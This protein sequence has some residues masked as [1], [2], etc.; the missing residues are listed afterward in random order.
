[1][2]GHDDKGT[3]S[4]VEVEGGEEPQVPQV[5]QVPAIGLGE[6]PIASEPVAVPEEAIVVPE[7][8]VEAPQVE[9]APLVHEEPARVEPIVDIP[10]T[11]EPALVAPE[12]VVVDLPEPVVAQEPPK[13]EK[14]EVIEEDESKVPIESV[15]KAVEAVVAPEEKRDP[16]EIAKALDHDV[17]EA[18]FR[19]LAQERSR[20]LLASKKKSDKKKID[21]NSDRV[22]KFVAQYKK[23]VRRTT[24]ADKLNMSPSKVTDYLQRLIA[25]GRVRGEGKTNDRRFYIA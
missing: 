20:T 4:K 12:P 17:L 13:A 8:S 24:I 22:E 5:D 1:M 10:M 3:S 9:V 21:E 18:A 7:N 15:P 23:G 25:S 2:D 16:M 14:P 11:P 6:I 19:L